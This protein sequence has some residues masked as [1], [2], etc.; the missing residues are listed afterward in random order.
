MKVLYHHRTMAD[1]AEGIHIREVVR[2]LREL[3]H[4]VR[5]VA[6]AGDPMAGNGA[7][8]WKGANGSSATTLRRLI[9]S[10][11]YEFA[12]IGYNAVGY[13]NIMAA[14]RD[15]RPDVIYDRYNSYST[16]AVRAARQAGLPLILEVNSPVA[17]ERS[18][19]E[20]LQLKLPKLAQRYERNIMRAADRIF[21]VSTPL[22]QHLVEAVGVDEDKIRVLPNGADPVRF[23]P[24]VSGEVVRQRYGLSGRVVIGFVG[25][26]RPWHGVDML[27]EALRVV[28]NRHPH[29]HLLI[30][31]D[32]PM[33]GELETRA[34][35]LGLTDAVTF[36]G[37]LT[38]DQVIAHVAAMD[39][40]VSPHATF[41]ASPMKILE[42]MAMGK[43]VIAP[44]MDNIRDILSDQSTGVL[45]TPGD[46]AALAGALDRV[47]SNEDMRHALGSRAR[48]RVEERF[49]WRYNA[50]A[51]VNEAAR[52]RPYSSFATHTTTR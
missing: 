11:A 7:N 33:Q 1:G 50:Q 37:R 15:F 28:R 34:H 19:Y 42:Y 40:S 47:V 51:V 29:A 43:A 17:Y 18:V 5:V 4:E 16:A 39:I 38:H 31:G 25:I 22:K 32:G 10:F 52:L 30:V 23:S 44:A 41:Y 13:R 9:P 24:E 49:N 12:E 20:N 3:R 21:A 6:L 35:A 36:T 14:V 48:A 46:A 2:A 26:L 27:L 8:R 45:F